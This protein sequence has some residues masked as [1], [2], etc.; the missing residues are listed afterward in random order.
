V[1]DWSAAAAPSPSLDVAAA[2][3]K[4]TSVRAV[5]YTLVAD[6]APHAE[7]EPDH[8][9]DPGDADAPVVVVSSEQ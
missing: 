7:D 6:A 1:A 9:P 8:Q 3:R 4:A 5:G 2:Q